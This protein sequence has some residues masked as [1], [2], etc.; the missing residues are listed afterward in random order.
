MVPYTDW[1]IA[2]AYNKLQSTKAALLTRK[3]AGASAH[4]QGSHSP[5]YYILGWTFL[6]QIK[7]QTNLL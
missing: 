2:P 5:V 4:T 3:Q 7:H 1:T 6:F